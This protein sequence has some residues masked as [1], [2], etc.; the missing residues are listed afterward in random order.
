[1]RSPFGQLGTDHGAVEHGPA[2]RLV[3]AIGVDQVVPGDN[4]GGRDQCQLAEA[5]TGALE[6]ATRRKDGAV[7]TTSG[8]PGQATESGVG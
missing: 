1:M 2:A 7:S 8:Q 4:L 5:V 3:T 6:H